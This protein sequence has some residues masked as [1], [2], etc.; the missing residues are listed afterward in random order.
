MENKSKK[1]RYIYTFQIPSGYDGIYSNSFWVLKVS[2]RL[3]W[4]YITAG[5]ILA[6]DDKRLSGAICFSEEQSCASGATDGVG[7]AQAI[8]GLAALTVLVV[9]SSVS[10]AIW[11]SCWYD[12]VYS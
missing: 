1:F 12:V 8:G 10:S 2:W 6:R 3:H 11:R 4:L 7:G 5:D 9:C